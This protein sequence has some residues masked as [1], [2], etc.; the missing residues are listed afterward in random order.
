MGHRKELRL[1]ASGK[2]ILFRG[3]RRGHCDLV[4][5]G[6]QH[7]SVTVVHVRAGGGLDWGGGSEQGQA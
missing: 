4:R 6:I 5:N 1:T 3:L 7:L 2:K